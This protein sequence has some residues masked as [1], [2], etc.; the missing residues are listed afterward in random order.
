MMKIAKTLIATLACPSA[1]VIVS[2]HHGAAH[3]HQPVRAFVTGRL[4][5]LRWIMLRC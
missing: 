3:I 1:A 4:K 2:A 5:A